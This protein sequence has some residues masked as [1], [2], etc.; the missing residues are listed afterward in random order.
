MILCKYH[1]KQPLSIDHR[2]KKPFQKSQL[3]FTAQQMLPPETMGSAGQP[4]GLLFPGKVA[5][6]PIS[7]LELKLSAVGKS[8]GAQCSSIPGSV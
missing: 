3:R 2:S 5:L 1:S 8:S 4:F 6:L 7:S